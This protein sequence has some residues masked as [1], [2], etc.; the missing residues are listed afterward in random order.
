MDVLNCLSHYYNIPL[1]DKNEPNKK[2][3]DNLDILISN[4]NDEYK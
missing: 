3:I 1:L 4:I 2:L